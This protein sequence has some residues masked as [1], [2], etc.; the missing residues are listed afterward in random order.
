MGSA[1]VTVESIQRRMRGGSQA[2][3]VRGADDQVY[4]AKCAGNPQ[5]TRT[6]INEWVVTRL[7][8]L[9]QARTPE[10][11][12]LRFETGVPGESLLEFRFGNRRIPIARGLHLGSRCPV[13]PE[14]VA[15]F[16]FLPRRLLSRIVNVKDFTLAFVLDKWVSQTDSRQ[17]IFVRERTGG[18]QSAKFGAYLIDHGMSF[19][20]TRWEFSDAPFHGVY[21]DRSIYDPDTLTIDC[22]AAVAQIRALPESAISAASQDVPLEWFEAGDRDKLARLLEALV[23]RRAKLDEIVDRA[24]EQISRAGKILPRASLLLTLLLLSS[25]FSPFLHTS[26]PATDL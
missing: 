7:L 12:L 21:Y 15:I 5:G 25:I 1:V 17:A 26:S 24:L 23:S 14:R 11:H 9:L 6:L 10:L 2:L 4:V 16:D 20:G 22:H 8:K 13:D 3:L 18:D 19:G